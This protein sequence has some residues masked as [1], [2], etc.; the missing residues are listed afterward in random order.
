[1]RAEQVRL[2]YR[3]LPLSV[4]ANMVG[5]L[6]L[7]GLMWEVVPHRHIVGWVAFMALS[8]AWRISHYFRFQRRAL[9]KRERDTWAG[10]WALGALVS[11]CTWGAASFVMSVPD[12][13]MHQALLVALVLG[14][15]SAAVLL[16]GAHAPSFYAFV[17]PALLPVVV[18]NA[19]AGTPA[20][21]TLALIAGI[22]TL[23]ILSFG[24]NYSRVLVE[25]LRNRFHI[26]ALARELSHQ[27]RELEKARAEAEL[28]RNAAELANRAKTNFFAAASH[29]LR[30]PLHA[31]GLFAAALSEKVRDPEVMQVVNSINAS[32]EALEGLFNELLD[33]SKIDAGA[34]KPNPTPFALSPLL[35]RLRMDFEP[36]AFERGLAL[37]VRPSSAY[38]MSDALLVE[39]ILRNLIGNALRYT[40]SGG[41]LVGARR[42]GREVVIEVHDSGAGIPP[43]ERERIF[44]EFY[45]I[46]N[47][48]R[49]SKRGLGLGL[50]IVRRLANLL[51]ARLLL[52][53]QVG[54]GSVFALYLPSSAAPVAGGPPVRDEGLTA[55]SLAG[56]LIVVVEDE[57]AVLEGMKVLLEGWGAD[58]VAAS[59]TA[60]ALELTSTHGQS[61]SLV[62][63]DYRLREGH[64][65]IEAIRALRS[66]F[67]RDIPAIIVSGNS[68]LLDLNEAKALGAHFLLKPVM[69][70]KLRTLI[71]YKLKETAQIRA[72]VHPQ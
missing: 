65:G 24:R 54:R 36:E 55:G 42:R 61:P 57:T 38:V 30:Q 47:A 37:R 4:G 20:H 2:L 13:P 66:H 7:S 58:V 6:V 49:H 17:V 10:L 26:E 35:E 43:E 41:V 12:S 27:N 19:L 16:I 9:E 56:N 44:E 32:V 70:A 5:T 68:A 50:S 63:V 23:A 31:L 34:I 69:P 8:Q 29:D 14:V 52:R 71:N 25:S 28:A 18:K 1:V 39:R 60:A 72:T 33:I 53:S 40:V 51:N 15:T 62:I 64:D 45:Q 3:E 59:S 21:F 48:E 46:G 67:G 22:S 11:G